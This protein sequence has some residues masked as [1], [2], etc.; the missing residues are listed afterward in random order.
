MSVASTPSYSYRLDAYATGLLLDRASW[1]CSP[2]IVVAFGVMS[3]TRGF[4][5]QSLTM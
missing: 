4:N 3:D 2:G 5:L 1:Q